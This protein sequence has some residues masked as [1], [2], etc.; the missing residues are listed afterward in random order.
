MNNDHTLP[1]EM[2]CETSLCGGYKGCEKKR[3]TDGDPECEDCLSDANSALAEASK[4]LDQFNNPVP[5]AATNSN[6]PDLDA[7]ISLTRDCLSALD[8]LSQSSLGIIRKHKD[9]INKLNLL[10]DQKMTCSSCD[11]CDPEGSHN[12]CKPVAICC[13]NPPTVVPSNHQHSYTEWPKV[14]KD[15]DWCGKHSELRN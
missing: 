2:D 6:F 3:F 10:E 11:Y 12:G 5:T 4:E 9:I 15:K 14:N 7:L 8:K 1:G 13:L